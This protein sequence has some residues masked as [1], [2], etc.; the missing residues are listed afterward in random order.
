MRRQPAFGAP[1][2]TRAIRARPTS[3]RRAAEGGGERRLHGHHR[4][5]PGEVIHA[6][7]ALGLAE[8]RDDLGHVHR[9]EATRPITRRRR[10]DAAR[11]RG[12]RGIRAWGTRVE[13]RG[14]ALS[15]GKP[16]VRPRAQRRQEPARSGGQQGKHRPDHLRRI[17]EHSTTPGRS[18]SSIGSRLRTS[19]LA[20]SAVEADRL[21][22]TP[23]R[24]SGSTQP[25][26]STGRDKF[27]YADAAGCDFPFTE[28]R[29]YGHHF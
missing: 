7:I 11:A 1:D 9:P 18:K 6:A 8:D 20:Q 10:R 29:R 3:A 5:L 17:P 25:G 16:I 15:S 4:K 13:K 24:R 21:Q 26:H 12:R 28:W 14:A 23:C 2:M 22:T 27:P 19:T